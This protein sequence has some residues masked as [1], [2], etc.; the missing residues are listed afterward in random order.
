MTASEDFRKL[1]SRLITIAGGFHRQSSPEVKWRLKE[2][3]TLQEGT[4]ITVGQI[5]PGGAAAEDGRM[6]QGDEIIEI[7]GKNVVG[8][9]HATAVQL[10]QQSAANGHVK[11]IVRRQKGL[12]LS[13]IELKSSCGNMK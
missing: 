3:W 4:C 10:M 12:P 2:T 13:L 6:R 1:N 5:V 8:E 7:D 11:L 9:S